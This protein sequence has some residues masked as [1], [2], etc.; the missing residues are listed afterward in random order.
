M[1]AGSA[2]KSIVAL[3]FR[4]LVGLCILASTGA[5]TWAGGRS[6]STREVLATHGHTSEDI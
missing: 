4:S 5:H 3:A 2:V 6:P 1:E